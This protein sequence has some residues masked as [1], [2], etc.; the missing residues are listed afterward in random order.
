[1]IL[2]EDAPVR[3]MA[4]IVAGLC[5]GAAAAQPVM[6]PT[7][8]SAPARG[9]TPPVDYAD[10]T[11]WMC[12]PGV[13][14]GTC[15]ANLDAVAIDAAGARTPAPYVAATNAPIDCFFVYPTTSLD[16]TLLSDL[17]PD[18][19]EKR[20]V[21]G[22][23][24]RLG[25]VC[26]LFAPIYHSL[27][28]T[29]LRW[30]MAGHRDELDRETPYRDVLAAWRSYLARDNR[31]RGVVLV[32]HSQGA[33]LLKRLIAEEID[34][35]PAQK[36]LVAAYLAGNTELS[37]TSFRRVKPCRS[38]GDT[39]CV[40]AWSTYQDGATGR[41]LFGGAPAGQAP[42]CIN[43]SAI[44]G[45]GLLKPYLSRPRTA[46]A[47]DPPY[48]APLNQLSAECVADDQGT[49]LRVRI[50]PGAAA[51]AVGAALARA[52]DN[53]PGWGLHPLD[54]SLVQGNMIDLIARQS[55]A[56]RGRR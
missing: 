36:R 33:I 4:M 12:R 28:M 26:R 27:T 15:S 40:I 37:A 48:I 13:D 34:G 32:G 25:A 1:M 8:Q 44:G 51:E 35:K 5:A 56:W 21:H 54:I 10:P 31:G 50:E 52:N 14:D 18:A 2:R 24:A 3:W 23:A 30:G 53:A 45:R 11:N 16:P 46:P 47:S 17:T 39:G 55:A 38:A 43:P 41:R 29:A 19:E 22:Q 49:V 42:L 7:P 9:E 6:P 20:T